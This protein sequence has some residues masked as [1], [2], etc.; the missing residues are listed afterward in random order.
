MKLVLNVEQQRRT[1]TAL[2]SLDQIAHALVHER[3][4]LGEDTLVTLFWPQSDS[5]LLSND[6]V[7]VDT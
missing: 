4:T 2:Q 6:V 5:K 1:P 7:I 3:E